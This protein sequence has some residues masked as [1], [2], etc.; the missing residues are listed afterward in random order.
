MVQKQNKIQAFFGSVICLWRWGGG[1]GATASP[2]VL[3]QKRT[4]KQQVI[5]SHPLSS[6]WCSLHTPWGLRQSKCWHR[7]SHTLKAIKFFMLLRIILG[8]CLGQQIFFYSA[9]QLF[10]IRFSTIAYTGRSRGMEIEF[11]PYKYWERRNCFSNV[12]Y[13]PYGYITQSIFK[14]KSWLCDFTHR[15]FWKGFII[16]DIMV[17]LRAILKPIRFFWI[18][19]L[20]KQQKTV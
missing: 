1:G 6:S 4:L 13:L 16:D 17:L 11:N 12:E 8:G 2:H 18:K 14:Q 15:T 9:E 19:F 10:C 7:T 20:N 5:P 3:K